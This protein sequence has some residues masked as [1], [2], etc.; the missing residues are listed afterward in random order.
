M[1]SSSSSSLLVARTNSA[2]SRM[3]KLMFAASLFLI[4]SILQELSAA[5]ALAVHQVGKSETGIVPLTET[6]PTENEFVLEGVVP[7]EPFT[8]PLSSAIVSLR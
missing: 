6:Q 3:K 8:N 4:N 5:N 1:L 7:A 2:K